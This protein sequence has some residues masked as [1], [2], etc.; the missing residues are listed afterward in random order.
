MIHRRITRFL[1]V[2]LQDYSSNDFQITIDCI[3]EKKKN[4]ENQFKHIV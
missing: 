2:I 3:K 4:F 1:N